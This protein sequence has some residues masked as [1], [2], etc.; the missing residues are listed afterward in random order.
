[1]KPDEKQRERP[2]NLVALLQDKQFLME[3]LPPIIIA[4]ILFLARH[5]ISELIKRWKRRR[6][7]YRC[8]KDYLSTIVAKYGYIT[9]WGML[10]ANT[11]RIPLEEL[12]VP[13]KLRSEGLISSQYEDR[14]SIGIQVDERHSLQSILNRMESPWPAIVGSPGSG[15]TTLVK[16]IAWV[17]G[18]SRLANKRLFGFSSGATHKH[19]GEEWGNLREKLPIVVN[20]HK[21]E[22]PDKQLSVCS[23][24]KMCMGPPL[25]DRC[26]EDLFEAFLGNGECIVMFDGLDEVSSNRRRAIIENIQ[27]FVADYGKKG[28]VFLLTCRE[29][30]FPGIGGF[31]VYS[32]CEFVRADVE[33]YARAWYRAALS[34]RETERVDLSTQQALMEENAQN[35]I[36]AV[37]N[38]EFAGRL[39]VN[40]L[41]LSMLALTY[42]P[43]GKLPEGRVEFYDE[44][45]PWLLGNMDR[46]KSVKNRFSAKQKLTLLEPLAYW[47]HHQPGGE[48]DKTDLVTRIKQNLPRIG[49]MGSDDNAVAF[50]TETKERTGVLVDMGARKYGFSH[51]TF[52][53]YL[54]AREFRNRRVMGRNELLR[55]INEP[56]WDEVCLFYVGLGA[57]PDAIE[58]VDEIRRRTP[59]PLRTNLFLA[60]RC[61][62]EMVVVEEPT[63][64][65]KIIQSLVGE[66]KSVQFE[67]LKDKA[68]RA[69]MRM[70]RS[71]RQAPVIEAIRDMLRQPELQQEAADMLI[72]LRCIDEA[73][74]KAVLKMLCSTDEE[75]L[76]ARYALSEIGHSVQSYDCVHRLLSH[77]EAKYRGSAALALGWLGIHDEAVISEIIALLDDR[78]KRV[79]KR[80]VAALGWIGNATDATIMALVRRLTLPDSVADVRYVAAA[81]L[82]ELGDRRH[83]VVSALIA[84]VKQDNDARVRGRAASSLGWL[85]DGRDE[86]VDALLGLL[87]SETET[88]D[89]RGRAVLAL[90]DLGV[91]QKPITERVARLLD[92]PKSTRVQ[93][94]AASALAQV[95]E[96]SEEVIT[97]LAARV[98]M[99]EA[100]ALSD[101]ADKKEVRQ[102][103]LV[104]KYASQAL[105]WLDQG[106]GEV[107]NIL[108]LLAENGTGS[109]RADAVAAI[110]QLGLIDRD[111]MKLVMAR[112]DDEEEDVRGAAISA[113]RRLGV[114]DESILAAI[115]DRLENDPATSVQWRAAMA[116]GVLGH[117]DQKIID[118]LI[119]KLEDGEAEVK[120]RSADAL[121]RLGKG[122]EPAANA[123][124]KLLSDA[125]PGVALH[126]VKALSIL[127]LRSESIDSELLKAFLNVTGAELKGEIATT[128]STLGC[129]EPAVIEELIGALSDANM[130]LRAKCASSLS[131]LARKERDVVKSIACLLAAE[132]STI[133]RNAVM[134]LYL[135]IRVSQTGIQEMLLTAEED[136]LDDALLTDETEIGHPLVG[137]KSKLKDVA[138]WLLREY[139]RTD[140]VR[141]KQR[142]LAT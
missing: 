89:V 6:L 109:Q 91:S 104:V 59:D 66:V 24:L 97:A 142:Y 83:E 98:R 95:G 38:N 93:W 3:V 70:A 112:I 57:N 71:Q 14:D 128:F 137:D 107:I 41:L 39:A 30:V 69:L 43:A 68:R 103:D 49:I 60:A 85:G 75:R 79:R 64:E 84:R 56:K 90:G 9:P 140:P 126:A 48:A 5:I 36:D 28:N 77:P 80:C 124:V 76:K 127:G 86:V 106:Y 115:T 25:T 62:E 119:S 2:M 123:L 51:R 121:V 44:C 19:I 12:Y 129:T 141:Y 32:L 53:E 1:M 4:A 16:Y 136:L 13:L 133:K 101:A 100:R 73:V 35:L 114:V 94:R 15:K 74:V 130:E 50:L 96:S 82:G 65:K 58:L 21:L 61:L 55:L 99:G 27:N 26:P 46:G 110:G 8:E 72:K 122:G 42:S 22:E 118:M 102:K 31:S 81:A 7:I 17:L 125:G 63:V 134:G 52:R 78:D 10:A 138:W 11:G 135:I 113:L 33:K 117:A 23:L 132:D 111:I 37:W 54:T 40:P 105:T 88:E 20:L 45:L 131:D 92:D 47:M 120:L 29:A 116:L 139:R 34:P 87:D 18:R 67:G 108:K